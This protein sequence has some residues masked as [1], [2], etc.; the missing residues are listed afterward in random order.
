[1]QLQDCYLHASQSQS[2][3]TATCESL[4]LLPDQ[5][6]TCGHL[7]QF[8][9]QKRGQQDVLIQYLGQNIVTCGLAIVSADSM[10]KFIIK[11][12]NRT[13]LI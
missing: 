7:N 2:H 6:E 9:T 3:V 1:M 12:P 4:D 5:E 13:Q 10:H 8:L 11:K